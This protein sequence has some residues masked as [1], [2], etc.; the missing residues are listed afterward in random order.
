MRMQVMKR[1]F[2]FAGLAAMMVFFC[3]G[4]ASAAVKL[5]KGQTVYIPS[6]SNVISGPPIYMT[7]PLRANLVIHNTDPSQAITVT[8][9]DEYNTEGKKVSSYLTAPVV[10]N[11]MGAMRVVVKESKKEAEGL[12]ANFIIQWQAEKKVTEPIIEC[13]I[14]GSLGAQGFSFATQGRVTQE[15]T[16]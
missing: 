4:P 16:E 12:G 1:L 9:I 11:S 8:R 14:I 7:V 13:L 5:V 2:G 10:L 3:G 15:Q 6:Y